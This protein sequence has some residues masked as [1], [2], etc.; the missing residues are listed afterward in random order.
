MPMARR[1]ICK[2]PGEQLECAPF[3]L[4]ILLGVVHGK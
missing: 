1:K 4:P 3:V 2:S